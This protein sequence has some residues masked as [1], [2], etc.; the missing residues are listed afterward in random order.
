MV[1]IVIRAQSKDSEDEELRV[2]SPATGYR[3]EN[4]TPVFRATRRHAYDERECFNES[5][6]SSH[7]YSELNA[8]NAGRKNAGAPRCSDRIV[9]GIPRFDEPRILVKETVRSGPDFRLESP[10]SKDSG[11]SDRVVPNGNRRQYIMTNFCDDRPSS[12]TFGYRNN[13]R[14]VSY[15]PQVEPADAIATTKEEEWVTKKKVELTTTRQIETRVKRQVVLEDGKVVEDSGPMVTTNTTEDTE[16]QE[17]SQTEVKPDAHILYLR[18]FR[19]LQMSRMGSTIYLTPQ[20]AVSTREQHRTLGDDSGS[21]K[22]VPITTPAGH[23]KEIQEKTVKTREETEE[24][25]ETENVQHLGDISDEGYMTAVKSGSSDVRQALELSTRKDLVEVAPRIV[26]QSTKTRKFID[27]EDKLE[28]NKI[29][30]DGKVVS[31]TKTTRLHEEHTDMDLPDDDEN[32][33]NSPEFYDTTKKENSQRYRKTKEQDFTEYLMNGKKIGE[34]IHYQVESSEGEKRGDDMEMLDEDNIASRLKRIKMRARGNKLPVENEIDGLTKNSHRNFDEEEETRKEETSKWLEHHFGSESTKSSKGS[35]E[36][37]DDIIPPSQ[38]SFINVTMKSQVLDKTPSKPKFMENDT[39][40]RRSVSPKRSYFMGIDHWS[41]RRDD[42]RLYTTSSP[43][44]YRPEERPISV[45]PTRH[46]VK[47]QETLN[48]HVFNRTPLSHIGNDEIRSS[49]V[50]RYERRFQTVLRNRTQ[51]TSSPLPENNSF[52]PNGRSRY[53]PALKQPERDFSDSGECDLEERI[54]RETQRVAES[55]PY[56]LTPPTS[57]Q[58]EPTATGRYSQSKKLYQRTRF[59]AD[60]P[61]PPQPRQ[62]PV[63]QKSKFGESF[64]K[65]V[66]KLRS[67]SSERKNK[68]RLRSNGSR[69]PSPKESTY[70]NYN[71]LDNYGSLVNN[72]TPIAPPRTRHHLNSQR[73]PEGDRYVQRYYLGEDPFSG[74]IYGREKEYEENFNPTK[75]SKKNREMGGTESE[76]E[77]AYKSRT[78]GRFSKSTS[79]LLRSTPPPNGISQERGGIQTLPRKLRNEKTKDTVVDGLPVNEVLSHRKEYKRKEKNPMSHA[80]SLINVSFVNQ[81]YSGSNRKQSEIPVNV[82]DPWRGGPTKPARTYRS[83]LARSQSFNVYPGQK[84]NLGSYKSQPH[85]R[86]VE[87]PLESPGMIYRWSRNSNYVDD[88]KSTLSESQ[89]NQPYRSRWL[90]TSRDRHV[91]SRLLGSPERR[92]INLN[93]PPPRSVNYSQSFRSTSTINTN[94][95]NST[96]DGF[97]SNSMR[98]YSPSPLQPVYTRTFHDGNTI[99]TISRS[100]N[101]GS[102]DYSETVRIESKSDD[103]LNPSETNTVKIFSKKKIPSRNGQT[104]ETVESRETK[105]VVKRQGHRSTPD[106]TRMLYNSSPSGVVIKVRQNN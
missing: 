71:S 48:R 16:K 78:L 86:A 96:I 69:S 20:V 95:T 10:L 26:H 45:T 2:G 32:R 106:H 29:E 80:R 82:E 50:E 60:I 44:G 98:G 30:P 72:E 99:K 52:Y 77:D 93:S 14:C 68:K 12:K 87:E 22:W 92:I 62:F 39:V 89:D 83:N 88:E 13:Q 70:Q 53:T 85:L 3:V 67:S 35:A 6:P 36:N 74:S 17:H 23:L 66:G 73:Q 8:G 90:G 54:I 4:P 34:K 104:T 55:K 19:Y 65:L 27:T 75:M 1:V 40:Q 105:T 91:S 28:R 76:E 38:N 103:P 94:E 84:G 42:D 18:L 15:F 61:P 37:L 81:P 59:A 97:Q 25:T 21:E 64:R 57:D 49:P 5:W 11:F 24:R 31:E 79:R 51:S 102:D 7:D 58:E 47:P 63:K 41:N 46:I 43:I 100:E 33:S 9:D 101:P 56:R